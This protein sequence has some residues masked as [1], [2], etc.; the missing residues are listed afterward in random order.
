MSLT[1]LEAC[2]GSPHTH[3]QFKTLKMCP[4]CSI[5]QVQKAL[6]KLFHKVLTQHVLQGGFFVGGFGLNANFLSES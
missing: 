3:L 4:F 1:W 5:I 2:E 6:L